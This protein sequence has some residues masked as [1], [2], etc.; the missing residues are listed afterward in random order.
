MLYRQESIEFKLVHH[1][2][3]GKWSVQ[4]GMSTLQAYGQVH[5]A[6]DVV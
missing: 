2:S 1:L 5:I 3:L 4:V 6:G